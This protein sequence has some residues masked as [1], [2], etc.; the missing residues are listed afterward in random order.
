[1]C[2][3]MIRCPRC[4]KEEKNQQGKSTIDSTL[5][6]STA[7]GTVDKKHESEQVRMF[8]FIFILILELIHNDREV[9]EGNNKLVSCR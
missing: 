5:L 7:L 9:I 8:F 2:I 4:K 3:E 6:K 1:M